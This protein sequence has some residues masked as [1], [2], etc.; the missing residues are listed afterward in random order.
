MTSDS[1]HDL[2]PSFEYKPV[3]TAHLEHI[4][5]TDEFLHEHEQLSSSSSSLSPSGA[6]DW[7]VL[8]D[9]IKYRI[10]TCLEHD[11]AEE[12]RLSLHP[13]AALI[14]YIQEGV[15]FGATLAQSNMGLLAQQETEE[16]VAEQDANA[17][18]N[19][20]TVAV[21]AEARPT[22]E[23]GASEAENEAADRAQSNGSSSSSTEAEAAT[24]SSSDA[25]AP[26]ASTSSSTLH[27]PPQPPPYISPADGQNFYPSKRLLATTASTVPRLSAAEISSATRTLYAMLDDFDLQPPFTI[28]R[29]CELVVAPTTHYNSG[30]K[31][32]AA[33][34]R[35]LSVTATRDA[36][37]ISP[38][39]TPIGVVVNG[40]HDAEGQSERASGGVGDMSELEMDR[41]DG[42]PPSSASPSP[43]VR[44]AG[45]T[46][47]RSSS[48]SSNSEPLFSPIPFILRD[49]NG[50]LNHDNNNTNQGGQDQVETADGPSAM[51]DH[52]PDL[53]L[54]GADRTH[55]IH[56]LPKEVVG[57]AP[58]STPNSTHSTA[59]ASTSAEEGDVHMAEVQLEPSLA[60]S[61]TYPDPTPTSTSTSASTLASTEPLGVPDGEVDEIDNPSHTVH[62]LTSTT[63]PVDQHTNSPDAQP[64]PNPNPNPN[65]ADDADDGS[66]STKRRKSV[67]SLPDPHP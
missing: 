31:W 29:L 54:G 14:P 58:T 53:E 18:T 64:N 52:I 66:R 6:Y 19:L 28:Q 15:D 5:D 55:T 34:K 41:L 32:V 24:S 65:D 11:F 3:Y 59:P 35:C 48:L 2:S 56:T 26:T 33:L 42:L 38:V 12:R 49:E 45:A 62:P 25:P 22:T 43:S 36:F 37:P 61:S 7:P 21:D 44:G 57:V 50:L 47:S 9:A 27:A 4:A 67:A 51:E 17:S 63:T 16:G 39:Q 13:A 20:E 46:R 23:A 40:T 30:A 1:L 10:R 60:V 8:K